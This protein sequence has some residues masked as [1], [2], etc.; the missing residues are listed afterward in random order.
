MT[1]SQTALLTKQIITFS[2]L[3]IILG[4]VSFI[5]YK[6]WHSYYL[7]HLP[8]IE[9]K[10]DTKFGILTVPDFPQTTASSSSFSYSIDTQTG[11][12]PQ[13]GIDPGFE[14]LQK[15]YFVNKTF[16]TLLSS[17]QSQNLAEKFN[18]AT[19]PEILSDTDYRF[20]DTGKTLT[21]DL[22]SGN[23][24]FERQATPS[25]NEALDDDT[26]LVS[27]FKNMLQNLGVLKDDLNSG[28][29]K[30]IKLKP[31]V[32]QISL[33]PTSINGKPI[34]TPQY[35]VSLVNA[36]VQKS[37]DNIENYLSLNFSY[38]PIDLSTFATYPI[39]TSEQALEDLKSG[40]GIIAV[41]PP[42]SNASITSVY[43]GYF[44]GQSYSPYLEPIFVFQGPHFVAYVSAIKEE[45]Q[46]QAR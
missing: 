40:K 28:L 32:A 18:I 9:E 12:L 8:I 27:D 29:S 10:P 36:K 41:E 43:L 3:V 46:T 25:G 4:I 23:F 45:F 6:I 22:D 1:L 15:V 33:W 38:F 26:K 16:A 39:K 14:K 24:I 30:V 37:A 20:S 35:D 5:G 31:N 19:S 42:Q 44:L 7:A 2:M 13:L 21:V 17:Q 11:N 34:L